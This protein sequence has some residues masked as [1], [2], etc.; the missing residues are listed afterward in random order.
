MTTERMSE[1]QFLA[2]VDQFCNAVMHGVAKMLKNTSRKIDYAKVCAIMK[3]EVGKFFSTSDHTYDSERICV[4]KGSLNDGV[5]VTA[6]IVN[7]VD[8]AI[9]EG[10]LR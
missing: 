3:D 1:D 9:A 4:L 10:A 7:C 8:R 5:I 6:V 2:G